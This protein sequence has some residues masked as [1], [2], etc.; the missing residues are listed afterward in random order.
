MADEK[1]QPKDQPKEEA[2]YEKSTA[3]VD[4]ERR[5]PALQGEDKEGS[6]GVVE[7]LTAVQ[8]LYGVEEDGGYIGVNPEYRNAADVRQEP[9]TS[10]E[11]WQKNTLFVEPADDAGEPVK[12][13]VPEHR[14][15]GPSVEVAFS[16]GSASNAEAAPTRPKT[17]SA[18]A[19][20]P[21]PGK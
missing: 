10:D 11:D 18:P 19:N 21:A 6:G 13:Y 14:P 20:K 9:L 8:P 5:A 4:A 16:N 3:Q 7:H 1:D 15:G 2:V 17:A 12:N